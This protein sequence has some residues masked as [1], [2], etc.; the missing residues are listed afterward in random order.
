V[1]VVSHGGFIRGALRLSRR[2]CCTEPKLTLLCTT[3]EFVA[4]AAERAAP[5][6]PGQPVVA[7]RQRAGNTAVYTFHVERAAANPGR[8]HASLVAANDTAHLDGLLS[9]QHETE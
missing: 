4:A 2:A 7:G 1:L 8:W 6:V 9:A 5:P 3:T